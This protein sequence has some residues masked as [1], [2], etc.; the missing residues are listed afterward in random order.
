[1]TGQSLADMR[2]LTVGEVA[3]IMRVSK[4]T[5]YRIVKSGELEAIQVGHSF[6][7]PEPAVKRYLRAAFVTPADAEPDHPM[8]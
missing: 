1:M 4:M 2:F 7:V 6:R 5:V 3:A 8:T